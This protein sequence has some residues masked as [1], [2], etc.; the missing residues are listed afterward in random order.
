MKI[1]DA[2]S[3]EQVLSLTGQRRGRPQPLAFSADGNRL[4]QTPNLDRLAVPNHRLPPP[5]PRS[6]ERG[7]GHGTAGGRHRRAGSGHDR[8]G[9]GR[10]GDRHGLSRGL[11]GR[12]HLRVRGLLPCGMRGHRASCGENVLPTVPRMLLDESIDFDHV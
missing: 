9:L 7:L 2:Q 10:S 12:D 3:G 11:G 8:R 1:W 5:V 6:L 4:A